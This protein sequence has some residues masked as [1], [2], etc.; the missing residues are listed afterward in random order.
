MGPVLFLTYTLLSSYFFP[1]SVVDAQQLFIIR[2]IILSIEPSTDVTRGTNVTLRCQVVV[3]SS[4]GQKDLSRVYT[5]HKDNKIF[6]TKKSNTV[7]NSGKFKCSVNIEGSLKESEEKSLKVTGL[8]K[9]VLHLNKDEVTEGEEVTISCA[10]PGEEG[11][12]FFYFYMDSNEISRSSDSNKTA[13]YETKIRL[14][15]TGTY[16][17][18]CLYSVLVIPEIFK[19][20]KSDEAVVSVREVAIKPALKIFPQSKVFEG[21]RVNIS[22]SVLTSI[23]SSQPVQL[24]L[25][26][27]NTLLT[28]GVNEVNH[29]IVALAKDPGDL[30]CRLEMGGVTKVANESLFVTELFSVPT[31]TM[32]PAEVFQKDNITL[33]CESGHF[34]SERIDRG[35]LDYSLDPPGSLVTQGGAGIFRGKALQHDFNYT[36]TAQAKG[37]QKQS[38]TLTVRPKVFVSTPTI[39]VIGRAILGEQFQILCRSDTGSLPINYTLL[40]DDKRVGTRSVQQPS[41]RA[42]F[43]VSV[44]KP[45]DIT[46]YR[47]EASNSHRVPLPSARLNAT[48]IVP[49]SQPFLR[50]RPDFPE[51][52]EGNPL[53]LSCSVEGTPP[54]NLT[55]YRED[56]KQPLVN[57]NSMKLTL[58]YHVERMSQ[59]HSGKYYCEAFNNASNTVRSNVV[60]IEVYLALWKKALIGGFCLLVLV[61]LVVVSV[62]YFKSK[63]G[64]RE[65]AAE[66]SVKPSSP[67]SDDSVSVNLTHNT[68]VYNAATDAAP[69]YDGTEGRVTNGLRHSAASLPADISNR[70]SYTIVDR[71]V[72]SVWSER[73]PEAATDE[74]SSV[75]SSE[76]DVEYTEVVHPQPVDPVRVP[77]RKGTDTVYSELKNSPHGAADPHDYGSVQYAE[78]NSEQPEIS[79]YSPEVNS[80]QDLPV[81]VD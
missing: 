52:Y 49:L 13:F 30:E 58:V 59:E 56:G 24:Y 35:E 77:L 81:P 14:S 47:C 71:A 45:D 23:H 17:I 53:Q 64:K 18:H 50:A 38:Q 4:T 43:P 32:S 78:L 33:I 46:R 37:I 48:V 63:R 31:L 9:P 60:H 74:V 79:H 8:S 29:S 67:K 1:G 10:A 16:R 6:Y 41:Q 70:S 75:L 36:C 26:Q 62:L 51:M 72:V 25:S 40:K 65:A 42:T 2:D 28:N 15:K 7:L 22:C 73:P 55:L 80:Y 21:D 3:S 69:L 39:S 20:N 11:P 34:A 76:P 44:T 57:A 27:G 5:I 12:I 66:L 19:S 68:E 61:L 54:V